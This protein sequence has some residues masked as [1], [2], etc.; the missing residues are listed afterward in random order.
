M[1]F[2]DSHSHY[3][4]EQYNNDREEILS[5][6]WSN[7]IKRVLVAGYNIEMSKKAIEIANSYNFIYASVGISPND[8]DTVTEIEKSASMR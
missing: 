3:N 2:F 1:Q 8:L 4:D 5:K 6:I 7:N